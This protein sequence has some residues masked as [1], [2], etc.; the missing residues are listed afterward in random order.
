MKNKYFSRKQ[1]QLLRRGPSYVAPCQL[2]L[3]LSDQL[4]EKQYQPLQQ[5][6][7]VDLV[8]RYPNDKKIFNMIEQE[9]KEEFYKIF[10]LSNKSISPSMLERS[11]HEQELIGTIQ[12]C[13]HEHNLILRRTTHHTNQFYLIDQ[14]RFYERCQNH[15]KQ[16]QDDYELVSSI[17]NMETIV[18]QHIQKINTAL[19]FLNKD[20]YQQLVLQRNDIQLKNVYFLFDRSYVKPIFSMESNVTS[21]LST[22]LDNLLRPTI[23]DILKDTFVDQ[24]FDFIQRL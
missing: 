18:N 11:Y 17:S 5:H 14:A 16:H 9:T 4:L 13:L 23:E 10:S 22:Y 2:K 6:L 19:N 8:N 12:Q 24:D 21:K 7:L 15:M 3:K 1:L 20:I